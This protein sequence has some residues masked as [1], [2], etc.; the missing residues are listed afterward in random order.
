[1]VTPGYAA[2]GDPAC[3][4][5]LRGLV[6]RLAADHAVTVVALRYPHRPTRYRL[7][8]ADVHALGGAFVR[9]C[10]RLRFLAGAC[11]TVADIADTVRADVI[12]GFWADEPGAVA[13]AARA[14]TG[15]P[16]VVSL[17]GG[18]LADLPVA[19]Y[20]VQREVIGR[21][22]VAIA[23]ASAD[24]LTAGSP[25]LGRALSAH[26]RGRDGTPV[27]VTPL[28]VDVDHFAAPAPARD[29]SKPVVVC[30][31]SNVP[32]KGHA[33]LLRA[34]RQVRQSSRDATLHLVG[35]GTGELGDAHEGVIVH[36]EVNNAELPA[37]LAP[38]SLWVQASW[39][40]AQSVALVEAA[41]ASV[42]VIGTQVGLLADFEPAIAAVRPGDADALA[43]AML[44]ALADPEAL[45]DAGARAGEYARVHFD[46]RVCTARFVSVY[47]ELA[48]KP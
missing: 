10:R 4:P 20:G 41:A 3:I 19:G 1:L 35:A 33:T 8:G 18:E 15:R 7:D 46:V 40:E 31:A 17:A 34:W 26:L 9:G 22:L 13:C 37:L 44:A 38:A 45:A 24:A 5:G 47:R 12:H 21:V 11:K 32:V 36:G 14:L 48:D 28:G 25:W 27:R 16:A 39:H 6:R 42:A 23:L 2:A 30:V 43:E 29:G